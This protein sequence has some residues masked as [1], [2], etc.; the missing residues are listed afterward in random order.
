MKTNRQVASGIVRRLPPVNPPSLRV[1]EARPRRVR[2]FPESEKTRVMPED[3]RSQLISVAAPAEIEVD[4]EP[5]AP[6]S[7]PVPAFWEARFVAPPPMPFMTDSRPSYAPSGLT[8]S[9]APSMTQAPARSFVPGLGWKVF[10][11]TLGL[12]LE[13]VSLMPKSPFRV[14]GM[15]PFS[16]RLDPATLRAWVTPSPHAKSATAQGDAVPARV[17]AQVVVVDSPVVDTP[18]AAAAQLARV[19]HN[20]KVVGSNPTRATE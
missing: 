16:L 12:I 3:Q 8:R 15:L 19:P 20:P 2:G 1:V 10:V 11:I 14:A 18:G 6:E 13:V 5:E 7:F 17:D 4:Y 9:L